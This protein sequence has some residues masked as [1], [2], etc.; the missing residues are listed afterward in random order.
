MRS[1]QRRT[2]N[3]ISGAIACSVG[4]CAGALAALAPGAA[5]GDAASRVVDIAALAEDEL[6]RVFGATPEGGRRGTPVAAGHDVDGDGHRD[7]AVASILASPFGRAGAGEVFLVFGD[8]ALA[9]S[10]DTAQPDARVLRIVGDATAEVAGAAIWID[11][12]TGDGLG[13]LLVG[14][15]NAKP[16]ATRPGAGALTILVGG[17]WLRDLAEAAG[18]LDLRAPPAE[19]PIVTLLGRAG[20]ARLG[21]WMRTGDVTG[22]GIADVAVGADQEDGASEPHQ[23]AVYLLRGGAHLA[24]AATLDLALFGTTALA[25]AE[26]VARLRPPPGSAELHFGASCQL[27]DLDGNERAEVIAAAALSRAGAS[28][29]ADGAPVGS[30]H[31]SGGTPDGTVYVAWDD[32]F[33]GATWPVPLDLAIGDAALTATAIDGGAAN[34][35]FGEELVG[36]RDWDGDG[37]ADLFV[38][39]LLGAAPGRPGAAGLGHLLFG[40]AALRGLAIDLDAPPPTLA[41][42]TTLVGTESGGIAADTAIDGDFDGDARP[43][44]AVGVPHGN[45]LARVEAG[46]VYVFFGREG[47]WPAEVVL[48]HDALPAADALRTTLLLGGSGAAPGGDLG[49]TLAY[50]GAAGDLDGDGASDLV[51]NEMTGNGIAAQDAGNLI[52]LS[53]ALLAAEPGG[54][55]LGVAALALLAGIRARRRPLRAA[56]GRGAGSRSPARRR[57]RGDRTRARGA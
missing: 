27:A 31:A 34:L 11:D 44:L 57:R 40:V 36:G 16:D 13:E 10:L 5:R 56:R 20:T 3:P 29:L 30:A 35:R 48:A 14:R 26:H 52:A 37:S 19:A 8:G 4:L 2:A 54:A 49:D 46:E 21:I 23:G 43:D 55:A 45:P 47:A 15:Q 38:G 18:V 24:A 28:I 7:L 50:S 22:D 9:G 51:V 25:L 17:A 39:D 1:V 53:G 33:A 41:G 6:L 32:A 42:V 12:V